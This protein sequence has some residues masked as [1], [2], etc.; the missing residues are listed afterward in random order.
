MLISNE[1][2]K[3]EGDSHPENFI[4]V[5]ALHFYTS[6]PES[7]DSDISKLVEFRYDMDR[8]DIFRQE[9]LADHTRYLLKEFVST[10]WMQTAAILAMCSQYFSDFH[11][12]IKTD[13]QWEI[14]MFNENVREYFSYILL[15]VAMVDPQMENVPL[16]RALNFSEQFGFK[17]E[18]NSILK[19]EYKLS[20]KRLRE[21]QTAA[22]ESV[23]K[24]EN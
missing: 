7:S 5:L 18:F 22:I 16:G 21:L 8:L 1:E 11:S 24:L 14:E 4:R 2:L 3:S 10:S 19:K 17:K 15:D 6:S 20:D 12:Q 13:W 9:K 23:S